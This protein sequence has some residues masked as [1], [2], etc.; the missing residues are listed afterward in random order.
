[1]LHFDEQHATHNPHREKVSDRRGSLGK[2]RAAD[3]GPICFF[4]FWT[5][6]NANS[7]GSKH[8]QISGTEQGKMSIQALKN[9]CVHAP[10]R[11]NSEEVSLQ[12]A[13]SLAQPV[14]ALA[15]TSG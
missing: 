12:N 11:S 15:D 14:A 4:V 7:A 8:A 9:K 1:M 5:L 3:P 10:I 13:T 2:I 6:L